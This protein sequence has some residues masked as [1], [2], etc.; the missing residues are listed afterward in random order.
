M[1]GDQE[2]M[3]EQR[4]AKFEEWWGARD[5]NPEE[6]RRHKLTWDRAWGAGVDAGWEDAE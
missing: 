2:H 4:D 3:H 6:K 5:G 1:S